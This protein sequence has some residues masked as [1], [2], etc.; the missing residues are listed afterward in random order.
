[1]KSLDTVT[2]R[3]ENKLVRNIV[4][5]KYAQQ[6]KCEKKMTAKSVFALS[7][8]HREFTGKFGWD[9]FARH[10]D[11]VGRLIPD[12]TLLQQIWRLWGNTVESY[13]QQGARATES[14]FL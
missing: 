11:G 7:H 14:G 4:S 13:R 6:A 12:D 3:H 5:N 8:L 1:M 2:V 9:A 10:E